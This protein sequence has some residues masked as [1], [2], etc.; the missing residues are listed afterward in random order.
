V[1]L[2]EGIVP[3]TVHAALE[4]LI[5]VVLVAAPFVLGF[6][7]GAA[8]ALAIVGGVVTLVHAAS[9]DWRL[10]VARVI[11]LR[12]HAVFDAVFSGV[13]IAAPFVFG[14]RDE[15][16]PT[17]FFIVLGIIGLLLTI[18]TRFVPDRETARR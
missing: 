10:A 12:V 15:N 9:T 8:T 13:M 11:P 2:R 1:I 3:L 14:F 6:D 17:A 5:G 18:G 4:Y 16:A 7:A